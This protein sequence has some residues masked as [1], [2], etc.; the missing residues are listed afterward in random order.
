MLHLRGASRIHFSCLSR[1]VIS[2]IIFM[3]S[4]RGVFWKYFLCLAWE[5][6]FLAKLLL[7]K[8]ST[9]VTFNLGLE[10]WIGALRVMLGQ[11]KWGLWRYKM[12][13]PLRVR[14]TLHIELHLT[15]FFRSSI[16]YLVSR[17]FEAPNPSSLSRLG[18]YL[19]STRLILELLAYRWLRSLRPYFK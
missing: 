1:R 18:D 9:R 14:L 7:V 11:A 4:L 17:I 12:D 15:C 2:D 5:G 8:K 6:H 19:L 16:L 13:N 3:L 10:S